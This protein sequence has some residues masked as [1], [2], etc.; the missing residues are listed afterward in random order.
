MLSVVRRY[1]PSLLYNHH[2]LLLTCDVLLRQHVRLPW[3]CDIP[4]NI[5]GHKVAF[6]LEV[7]FSEEFHVFPI[8]FTS[9][10][11]FLSSLATQAQ[12]YTVSSLM[13]LIHLISTLHE[14]A[15]IPE[16]HY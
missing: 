3:A 16:F 2:Q 7:L 13:H 12:F 9:C 14:I 10:R 5:G 11:G 4:Q 8:L 6:K 1:P 15:G